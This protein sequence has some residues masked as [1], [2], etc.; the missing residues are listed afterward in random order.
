MK[1]GTLFYLNLQIKSNDNKVV[2]GGGI[3]DWEVQR[4]RKLS[5]PLDFGGTGPGFTITFTGPFDILLRDFF[6]GL[7]P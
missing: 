5:W 4:F 3:V 1:E 6:L 2:P 7:N